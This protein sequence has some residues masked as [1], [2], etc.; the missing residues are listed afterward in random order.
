MKGDTTHRQDD[1]RSMV[2]AISVTMGALL[3]VYLTGALGVEIE[4][5]LGLSATQLGVA[6]AGFFASSAVCAAGAGR[7]ADRIGSSRGVR[8]AV[9][10]SVAAL[11]ALAVGVR[12]WW[13][14]TVTLI[15]AGTANGA[16]QPAA[17][18]FLTRTV[19]SGRQ[20]FAFGVK[21]AAIPAATMLSGI[22]VPLVAL[23][24]GWR[25]AFAGAAVL[26]VAF[27]L[28]FPTRRA[29]LAAAARVLP[30]TSVGEGRL[31]AA[32]AF[33][34]GP[35]VVLAA[36]QAL[37]AAAT[38]ALG[39]FFVVAATS[40]GVDQARAGL[41][42]AVGSAACLAVRVGAGRRA[43][44]RPGGH[45]RVVALLMGV[46]VAG[47][48]LLAAGRPSLLL[49]AALLTYG[50]GWGWPGLFNFG[51]A[52]LYPSVPGRATGILQ[53]GASSGGALGPLVFGY[54]AGAAG[55]RAAWLLA[56]LAALLGMVLVLTGRRQVIKAGVR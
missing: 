18:R 14:L 9:V 29:S 16:I 56:G 10:P 54:T 23:A 24:V 5:S 2:A 31:V 52:R 4:H 34:R 3:A 43:D 48:L 28:A 47:F 26:V 40:S 46:G 12:S 21:Q 39:S 1:G 49:P 6:V 55:F 38:V 17:N 20:G 44:R 15:V 35:L 45:L 13:S 36:G 8:T 11:A 51:V 7:L 32:P 41:I 30:A 19:S 22:A 42:A 37:G 33:R 27:G 53:V 25:W 50:A